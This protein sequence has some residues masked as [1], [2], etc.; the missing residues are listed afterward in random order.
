[1]CLLESCS[2]SSAARLRTRLHSLLIGR[3]TGPEIFL[4]AGLL[5]WILFQTSSAAHG[6]PRKRCARPLSSPQQ[7]QQEMLSFNYWAA[8]L[9]SHVAPKKD[10]PSCRFGIAFKH[11]FSFE[12]SGTSIG[13]GWGAMLGAAPRWADEGVCAPTSGSAWFGSHCIAFSGTRWWAAN[14]P[15]VRCSSSPGA[16]E[17]APQWSAPGTSQSTTRAFANL[18]RREWR[19][20]ILLSTAP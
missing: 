14:Q 4:P 18:I 15:K 6:E 17:I 12:I 9:A 1:M 7:S 16:T 5:C 20:G 11:G 8:S 19:T 3:S 2:A 10:Y 13:P